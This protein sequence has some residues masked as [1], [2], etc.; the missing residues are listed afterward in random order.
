MFHSS[1]RS[2]ELDVYIESLKLATEYQG[3][4]HYQNIF[5]ARSELSTQQAIDKEKREACKQV[6]RAASLIY[7]QRMELLLLRFRIG[8]IKHQ[9]VFQ[10]SFTKLGQN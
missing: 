8:G 5:A 3:E 2:M 7:C 10:P 9:R 4:Q 6:Q 1:G